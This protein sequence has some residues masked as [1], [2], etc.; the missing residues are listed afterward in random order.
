ML[1]KNVCINPILKDSVLTII[2][3]QEAATEMC[4]AKKV[5]WKFQAKFFKK[6]EI[7]LISCK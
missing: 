2:Y 6:S 7:E 4:S 3:F 5:F 1:F